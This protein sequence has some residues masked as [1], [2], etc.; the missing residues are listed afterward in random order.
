[1]KLSLKIPFTVLSLLAKF[2]KVEIFRFVIFNYCLETIEFQRAGTGEV[3][4]YEI[5]D[6]HI[7]ASEC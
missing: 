6:C 3:Q 7:L 4:K 2:F 1:M 5:S